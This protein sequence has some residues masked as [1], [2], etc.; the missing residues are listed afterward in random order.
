MEITTIPY[1]ILSLIFEFAVWSDPFPSFP[2]ML[3]PVHGTSRSGSSI[4]RYDPELRIT[5]GLV[6]KRWKSVRDASPRLWSRITVVYDRIGKAPTQ[7]LRWLLARSGA[8]PLDVWLSSASSE[9]SI[10]T[11]G[12]STVRSFVRLSQ[13]LTQV[14]NVL[15]HSIPRW[16]SLHLNPRSRSE[17]YVSFVRFKQPALRLTELTMSA[18]DAG[19]TVQSLTT[20]HGDGTFP[21]PTI[22]NNQTPEL[23]SVSIEPLAFSIDS[24]FIK[25]LHDIRLSR[26]WTTL[27]R[28]LDVLRSNPNL[29]T[30]VII[31]VEFEDVLSTSN[32]QISLETKQEALTL[33]ALHTMRLDLTRKEMTRLLESLTLPS[34]ES[35]SLC[36]SEEGN[37]SET[38]ANDGVTATSTLLRVIGD[39][40]RKQKMPLTSFSF[41][42][43]SVWETNATQGE[44]GT[45]AALVDLLSACGSLESLEVHNYSHYHSTL[46]DELTRKNGDIPLICPSLSSLHISR[47]EGQQRHAVRRFVESRLINKQVEEPGDPSLGHVRS[48]TLNSLVIEA[49]HD[50]VVCGS[51]DIRWIQQH[52][53]HFQVE[54]FGLL[55]HRRI[56]LEDD[57]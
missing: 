31:M 11:P 44:E 15:Q 14:I 45:D 23:R 19:G 51:E 6:C 24:Q 32:S 55:V 4:D 29:E 42:Y 18:Q 52:V 37:A 36:R 46:L 47:C 25:N 49:S 8:L 28:L 13:A 10:D 21:V 34:L 5:I 48:C 56:V 20:L 40:R 43:G 16:R 1:E 2:S 54:Q 17:A 38:P 22:F 53:P 57:F 30:L 41:T 9:R 3:P 35:L 50:K 7:T 33:P 26:G 12:D 27:S 39:Q